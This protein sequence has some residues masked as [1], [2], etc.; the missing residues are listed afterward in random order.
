MKSF[1]TANVRVFPQD[2]SSCRG[3]K[4]QA[5]P[6]GSDSA[7]IIPPCMV[8]ETFETSV[9]TMENTRADRQVLYPEQ[10]RHSGLLLTI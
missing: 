4:E 5:G 6:L 3:C 1:S 8:S 7:N 2:Y 10:L 9:R